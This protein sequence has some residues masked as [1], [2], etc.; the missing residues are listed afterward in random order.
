MLVLGMKMELPYEHVQIG[1]VILGSLAL[2]IP[3]LVFAALL[4][5]SNVPLVVAAVVLSL[6]AALFGT[7]KVKVDRSEISLR[8]GVGV[9]RR[10]IALSDV[11]AFAEVE[12]PWYFGWGIRY[13]P[14]G[15]LY[16]VSGLAAVEL[17]LNDGRRVRLGTNESAKLFLVLESVLGTSV[18]LSELPIVPATRGLHRVRLIVISLV[19]L[20]LLV[21]P[22]I[23]HFQARPPVVSLTSNSIAVENLF[24]GQVYRL[25]E[26]TRVE[27]VPSL[28]PIRLRTN[29]Y[30]AAGTLRGWFSLEK[31]GQGKLFVEATQPP[32]IAIFLRDGFVVINYRDPG[33]TRR[34]FS[35]MRQVLPSKTATQMR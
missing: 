7:L 34:L 6:V 20:S 28:P 19:A 26:I 2:P 23:I 17:A 12:T 29:G 14:G 15:T 21:L 27:L 24:Y 11:K 22:F 35:A 25:S 32:Y 9:I 30:A 10:R 16:N 3:I 31:W 8:L 18:P 33:E 1:W 4:A 13:Y 5:G